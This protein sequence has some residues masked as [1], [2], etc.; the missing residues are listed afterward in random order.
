MDP[1]SE[2]WRGVYVRALI[3][4]LLLGFGILFFALAAGNIRGNQVS[5]IPLI[6]KNV[7]AYGKVDLHQI[8][9]LNVGA[10]SSLDLTNIDVLFANFIPV[11]YDCRMCSQQAAAFASY[12]KNHTAP[13]GLEVKS[14]AVVVEPDMRVA[15]HY[16]RIQGLGMPVFQ[17]PEFPGP[18]HGSLKDRC[19]VLAVSP[20]TKKAL[21]KIPLIG[22]EVKAKVEATFEAVIKKYNLAAS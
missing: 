18:T 8:T 14:I 7:L 11:N 12:T 17:Q 9:A 2:E 5:K 4:L 3:T 1:N 16:A 21:L 19:F 10:D 6:E 13:S 22:G 20:R 15:K